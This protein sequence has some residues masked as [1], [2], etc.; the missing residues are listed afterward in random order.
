MIDLPSPESIRIVSVGATLDGQP[1]DA[2][3][4]GDIARLVQLLGLPN[5]PRQ[6]PQVHGI[7]I[8]R[9]GDGLAC[10]AFYVQEGQAALVRHAD[11][12]PFVVYD[13]VRSHAVIA[14]CG[15]KGIQ[16]GL[17]EKCVEF[18]LAE[19]SHPQDLGAISGPCIGAQSFEVSSQFQTGF[20]PSTWSTTS[21]GTH[22]VDLVAAVTERLQ[23]SGLPTQSWTPSSIDT[24]TRSEW[25]SHRRTGTPARNATLCWIPDSRGRTRTNRNLLL[26]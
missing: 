17:P 15:W 9:Q 19:G 13:P 5:T 24:F 1:F 25:H 14:H 26:P 2:C 23:R 22:S 11:C 12:M 20:A 4:P 3:I 8:D 16:S 18:L 21:W 10:D 6:A 7:R